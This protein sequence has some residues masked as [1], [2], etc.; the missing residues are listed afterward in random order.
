MTTNVQITE[1][2][3]YRELACKGTDQSCGGCSALPITDLLYTHMERL[4]SIRTRLGIPLSVTSGHRCARHNRYS[5]GAPH[6]MHLNL[7]TDVRP[8][9][10]AD[11]LVEAMDDIVALAD[12][13]SLGGIGI[14]ND[15]VHL[16]SRE[17]IGRGIARWNNRT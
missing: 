11:N 17:Y 12:E 13:M 2:F 14:Y 16:D 5:G 15:F 10:S 4:Q 8:S 3:N 7:A 1:N 6:S 9:I